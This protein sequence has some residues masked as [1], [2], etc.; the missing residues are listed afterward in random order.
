MAES[1]A[2]RGPGAA[3]P[4]SSGPQQSP[5]SYSSTPPWPTRSLAIPKVAR[6][7]AAD[8]VI[9]GA[10][11][12]LVLGGGGWCGARDGERGTRGSAR[13]A[14]GPETMARRS[15]D[16]RRMGPRLTPRR[17]TLSSRIAIM[18]S[19][20]GR[21]GAQQHRPGRTAPSL[22]PAVSQDSCRPRG[23]TAE[24]AISGPRPPLSVTCCRPAPPDASSLA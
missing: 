22:R 16:P 15:R 9:R 19:G 7:P 20:S 18:C 23:G 4:P 8:A 12:N 5:T 10:R 3:D 21:A 17:H 14:G 2:L 24:A 6:Y 11:E 1:R 13:E